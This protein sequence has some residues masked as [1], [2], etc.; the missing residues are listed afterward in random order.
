M[1]ERLQRSI[2]VIEDEPL[3]A[4]DLEKLLG[5]VGYRVVGPATNISRALHFVRRERIDLT[6][7]DLNLR[8]EMVFP[9]L[10]VLAEHG[11]P[12]VVVTGHSR[13]MLPGPHRTRPFLQK[14]YEPAALLRVVH[15]L[16]PENGHRML[17]RA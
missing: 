2:L 10:D 8:G 6:V 16:L 15:R 11:I 1:N 3:L 5:E 12:F 17:E 14:P 13:E 4:M 7:L 9:L